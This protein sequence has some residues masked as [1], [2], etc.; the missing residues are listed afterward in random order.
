MEQAAP[1]VSSQAQIYGSIE[2]LMMIVWFD[3][4]FLGVT[5][6][7]WGL[8]LLL[9]LQTCDALLPAF[10]AHTAAPTRP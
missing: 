2:Y 10:L 1:Q 3:E 9:A 8:H 6:G 7:A 5:L 4:L